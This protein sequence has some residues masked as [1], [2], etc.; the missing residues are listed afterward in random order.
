MVRQA[1][2]TAPTASG[3]EQVLGLDEELTPDKFIADLSDAQLVGVSFEVAPKFHTVGEWPVTVRLEDLSGNVGFVETDCTILGPVP[4][5]SIEAGEQVPPLSAF[6]PN[7]TM[8]GRFVTDVDTVDTSVPGVHMI[9]VEAEGREMAADML[10]GAGLDPDTADDEA[11]R[12]ASGRTR[13]EHFD[14]LQELSVDGLKSAAIGARQMAQD[15]VTVTEADYQKTVASN[16]EGLGVSVEE[17]A[18]IMPWPKY[19]RQTA[20]NYNFDII[21]AF[22]KAWLNKE[23]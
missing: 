23:D 10:R 14:F 3:V 19:L 11:V 13:Q 15:G 21:V 18:R 8:S 7:D 2:T 22:A 4:R 20:A 16:A 5:L 9:R 17:A 6:L 12:A 1:D